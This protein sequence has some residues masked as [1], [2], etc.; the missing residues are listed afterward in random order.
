MWNIFTP[1]LEGADEAGHFC[2]ADYI[3]HRNKLPNLN[4]P[5][6]CFLVYQPFYYMLLVPVIK[7]FS[8][9]EFK[10]QFVTP[11]P[12]WKQLRDGEYAQ[13]VHGKGE[14]LFRWNSFELMIHILRLISSAMAVAIFV[15]AWKVSKVVFKN[16]L[17][18]NL[19]LLLFFNPM[20]L[21][22]FTTLTNVTLVSLLASLFIAIEIIYA[23]GKKPLN[24][25]FLQGVI[26]GLGLLTKISILGVGLAY[27]WL[28]LWQWKKVSESIKFKIQKIAVFIGGTLLI[29]GW[30]I[31]RSLE[32]YGEPLEV[33]AARPYAG[34]HHWT[35]L[36]ELG[37]LNFWNSF[38]DTVFR[39]FWSGYGALTVNFPS[40]LNLIILLLVLFITYG[41]FRFRDKMSEQLK[42]CFFYFLS[43][44]I[45]LVIVNIRTSSM[46]AKDLFTGY[47]PLGFLFSFGLANFASYVK[48]QATPRLPRLF[49]LILSGYFFANAEVVGT[50][51][52][53]YQSIG[54]WGFYEPQSIDIAKTFLRLALKIIILLITYRLLIYLLSKFTLSPKAIL[55]A[56]YALAAFNLLVL[57]LSVYLF[58]FRFI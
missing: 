45:A 16:K 33:N 57:A 25:T 29:A 41:A 11:N 19:N 26:V 32:L 44:F 10:Y 31:Y 2:H 15:T 52:W 56:T 46:H 24:L 51:K 37:F 13:F 50:I 27:T 39:T 7:A 43:V 14:L 4:I 21:H 38:A 47:I 1:V 8:F 20:F 58:Y 12:N 34:E 9:D 6:G 48:R 55:N 18:R 53:F 35:L 54:L 42:V 23:S 22:I 49:I 3:A 36:S 5:D 30:Y 17:R 40:I 28:F